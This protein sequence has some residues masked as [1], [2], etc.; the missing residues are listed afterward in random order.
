MFAVNSGLGQTVLQHTIKTIF[1]I[2]IEIGTSTLPHNQHNELRVRFVLCPQRLR[3]AFDVQT[4]RVFQ[5]QGAGALRAPRWSYIVH[6]W[7]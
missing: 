5:H 4:R 2:S 6:A 1:F 7:G 3:F